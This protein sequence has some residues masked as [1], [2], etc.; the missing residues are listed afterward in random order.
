[1]SV[2]GKPLGTQ[3]IVLDKEMALALCTSSAERPA[4]R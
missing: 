2:A 4:A 1:M 3:G